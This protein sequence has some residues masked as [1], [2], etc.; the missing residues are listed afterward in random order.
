MD[1][2]DDKKLIFSLEVI[3]APFI[4]KLFDRITLICEIQQDVNRFSE[5]GPVLTVKKIKNPSLINITGKITSIEEEIRGVIDEQYF[6]NWDA[7]ADDYTDVNVGDIVEG[8]C[9][10]CE[11]VND[12]VF[13]WRCLSVKLKQSKNSFDEAN[14]LPI[15]KNTANKNG[16]EITENVFV[17]FNKK[18]ETKEFKMMVKNT[19]TNDFK[20]LKSVFVGS[21][22]DTQLTLISPFSRAL[23][24]LKAGEV[25]EYKFKATSEKFGEAR[26]LFRITFSGESTGTFHIGRYIKVSVYDTER[27]HPTIGTGSNVHRNYGYTHSVHTTV[28]SNIISGSP[29]N[30]KN[31]FVYVKFDDWSIPD[32][33]PNIVFNPASSRCSINDAL[34][35]RVPHLFDNL[36]I[37]NYSQIFHDLL[38]LEECEME[39][40]IRKYDKTSY[41]TREKELLALAMENVAESRPSIVVG[42]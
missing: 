22:C 20:V 28:H 27:S 4:P 32:I 29:S 40:G 7:L 30:S 11:A 41:F 25:K 17:D 38:Y 13:A 16:V 34:L 12:S 36:N 31:N 37:D 14:S 18:N 19:S 10:E 2:G 6:F 35:I 24:I 39:H 1:V 9:I 8:E 26:E 5:D 21:Q 3:T 42:E 15:N 23:F 33:F